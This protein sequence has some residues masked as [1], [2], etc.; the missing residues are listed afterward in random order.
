M[1]CKGCGAEIEWIRTVT[2]TAMPVDPKPIFFKE[3]KDGTGTFITASGRYVKGSLCKKE[4]ADQ[5]GFVSHFATCS[6]ADQFR[7]NRG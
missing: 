4:D 2:G 7:R 1:K 5:H 3:S 6:A